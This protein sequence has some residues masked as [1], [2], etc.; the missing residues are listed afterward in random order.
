MLRVTKNAAPMTSNIAVVT[1]PVSARYADVAMV[2]AA[3]PSSLFLVAHAERHHFI[4]HGG[5]CR[6]D[7]LDLGG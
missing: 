1:A 2:D 6:H 5:D 7:F 4:L 3:S